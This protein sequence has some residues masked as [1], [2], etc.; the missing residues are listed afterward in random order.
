[1]V[2][3]I[4]RAV[5]RRSRALLWLAAC[6]AACALAAYG[7]WITAER[8]PRGAE[9]DAGPGLAVDPAVFG[10]RRTEEVRFNLEP[11]P[12]AATPP[13]LSG[14]TRG[15]YAFFD[16]PPDINLADVQAAW[17]WN[18]EERGAVNLGVLT[19]DEETGAS[20]R[21]ALVEPSG[22][23]LGPGVGEFEATH[24]GVRIARGSFVTAE[25][26][27]GI[28]AQPAPPTQQTT[29]RNLVT[30]GGVDDQGR[31]QGPATGF[32]GNEKIWV[33][34]EYRGADAGAA[35]VVRWYCEGHELPPA[36]K[37][38]TVQGEAGIAHAWIGAAPGQALP[39]AEYEVTVSYGAADTVLGQ[40]RF[41][42]RE[43][44]GD[45][46]PAAPQP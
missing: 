19:R 9:E 23:T 16:L 2:S 10:H 24:A 40:A 18:G 27:G 45:R 20:I 29:V 41:R 7:G 17:W 43:G 12:P 39:P 13:L 30:A 21:A 4:A 32:D 46:P 35:F 25:Q 36:R 6:A 5:A 37:D 34:F 22:D 11:T 15:V 3:V 1:M 33:V 8:R 38:V 26:A 14:E 28:L 44:A 31:P 42:V